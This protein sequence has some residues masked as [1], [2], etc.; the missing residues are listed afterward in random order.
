MLT[1]GQAVVAAVQ[2]LRHHLFEGPAGDLKGLAESLDGVL[3]A[4]HGL[5]DGPPSDEDLPEDWRADP[6]ADLSDRFPELGFYPVVDPLDRLDEAKVVVGDA[7][8]DLIDIHRDLAEAVERFHRFGV[9]DA[10]WFAW[11]TFRAHWGEH[12]FNVRRYLHHLASA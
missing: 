12:L 10:G 2:R 9:E 1:G 7:G 8:D 11:L 4:L 3:A 5:P 6:P